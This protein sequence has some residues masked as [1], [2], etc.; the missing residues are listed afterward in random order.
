VNSIPGFGPPS[1]G[2]PFPGGGATG[3]QFPGGGATGGQFPG[4]P[5][6]GPPLPASSFF[7]VGNQVFVA[8]NFV[9][10]DPNARV[11]DRPIAQIVGGAIA[12][13]LGAGVNMSVDQTT[14]ASLVRV[15]DNTILPMH[16]TGVG[17]ALNPTATGIPRDVMAWDPA[18]AA[19]VVNTS[20]GAVEARPTLADVNVL[21]RALGAIAPDIRAIQTTNGFQFINARDPSTLIFTR[22]ASA[23]QVQGSGAPGTPTID[24]G[25]NRITLRGS[26]VQ[27][28][29]PAPRDPDALRQL[30]G[31]AAGG[32]VDIRFPDPDRASMQVVLP[33]GSSL[34]VL[35]SAI[36]RVN[37]PRP[38]G[39]Y[40]G[41]AGVTVVYPDQTA[42]DFAPE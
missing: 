17:T 28:L 13:T 1:A 2:A 31:T 22:P 14:G 35:P 11:G 15:G 26:A 27:D 39:I 6:F 10:V 5:G 9:P 38:S 32:Q 34:N 12:N 42:Q 30:V 4:G 37:D 33:G 29:L 19:F 16:F 18:R 40:P 36:V 7:G 41:A 3:S 20:A 25:P 23:A 8:G 24:V 21:D